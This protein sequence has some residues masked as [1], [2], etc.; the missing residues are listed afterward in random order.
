MGATWGSC[1]DLFGAFLEPSEAKGE[2]QE[3]SNEPQEAQNKP[4]E[5]RKE[6][7]EAQNEPQETPRSNFASI[8]LFWIA[9]IEGFQDAGAV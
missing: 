1:F 7:Q 3:A 2:P 4:Q 6:P 8:F 9:F 5:T